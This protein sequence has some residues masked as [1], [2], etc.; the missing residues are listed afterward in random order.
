MPYDTFCAVQHLL[1]RTTKFSLINVRL[2]KYPLNLLTLENCVMCSLGPNLPLPDSFATQNIF[3][4]KSLQGIQGTMLWFLKYF[5]QKMWQKMA[6]FAQTTT[7]F[8]KKMITTL[9]FEKNANF[10]PKIAENCDHNI[11]PRYTVIFI[12]NVNMEMC[13]FKRDVMSDMILQFP[14]HSIKTET[15]IMLLRWR[16]WLHLQ[17]RKAV[18]FPVHQ[19][20]HEHYR[21]QSL[22]R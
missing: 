12:W 13:F 15:R 7:N 21:M 16:F 11:D 2:F 18:P 17:I 10:L 14:K 8:C 5:R 3:I 22:A 19:K 9:V 20:W 1:C 6:F 4:L